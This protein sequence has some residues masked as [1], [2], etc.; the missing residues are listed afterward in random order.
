[1]VDASKKL[2]D[3]IKKLSDDKK[4]VMQAKGKFIAQA[5]HGSTA[6]VIIN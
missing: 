2:M 4:Y 6:K 1:L 5:D 3:E